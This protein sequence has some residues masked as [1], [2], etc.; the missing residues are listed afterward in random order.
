MTSKKYY[1]QDKSQ[2]IISEDQLIGKKMDEIECF[3][4]DYQLQKL[5]T[6]ERVYI[7][8]KTF[9]GIFKIRLYLYLSEDTVYNYTIQ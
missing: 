3:L 7:L 1:F 4:T 5:H 2:N 6:I 9:F 8:K